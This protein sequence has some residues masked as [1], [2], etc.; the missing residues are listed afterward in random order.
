MISDRHPTHHILA[1]E[2]G[3]TA[4]GAGG[5][6]FVWIVD[7][8]DGTTNYL[9]RHPYYAASVA[10]WDD[11]GPL[12]GVVDAAALGKRWEAVRG[13]GASEDG[14]PMAVSQTTDLS[15]CLIGTGFPFKALDLADQYLGQFKRILSHTAGIRR[16]GAAAIDLAYVANGTIDAFWELVL[17][18]WDVAAGVLLVTEAG[19]AVERLEGGPV[20]TAA[21]TVLAANSSGTLAELRHVALG[22]ARPL[23]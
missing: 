7:P 1:E 6:P 4:T 9:H 21:G 11:E 15:G 2:E 8:L 16:A 20:G 13:H 10:V 12:V 5:E 18:P 22:T 17:H 19:G 23:D 3:G 14:A